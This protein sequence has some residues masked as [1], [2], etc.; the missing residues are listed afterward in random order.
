[1]DLKFSMGILKKLFKIML[2]KITFLGNNNPSSWHHA[3]IVLLK[4]SKIIKNFS[5]LGFP[6]S[7]IDILNMED[8]KN[9]A[10]NIVR[11]IAAHPEK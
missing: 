10:K 4:K 5:H 7:S 8:W 9:P 6:R 2:W 1:M 3:L 11:L